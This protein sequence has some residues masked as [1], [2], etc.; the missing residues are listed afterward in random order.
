MK[1]FKERTYA[2]ITPSEEQ[3][4]AIDPIV[5]RYAMKSDSIRKNAYQDFKLMI[6]D[7]HN[8]LKPYLDKEQMQ[9]L[10]YFPKHIHKG[11][12]K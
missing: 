11:E 9:K 6:A 4:V 1:R 3:I 5:E 8:E 10:Y 2:I 7:F 12:R